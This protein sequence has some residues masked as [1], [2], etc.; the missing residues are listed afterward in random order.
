[1]LHDVLF[2]LHDNTVKLMH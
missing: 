2:V 1:M